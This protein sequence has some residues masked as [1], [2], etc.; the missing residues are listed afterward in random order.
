MND[1]VYE[2]FR[3]LIEPS[4]N[5]FYLLVLILMFQTYFIHIK[6]SNGFVKN[7]LNH[8][9]FRTNKYTDSGQ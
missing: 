5:L 1:Q 8:G 3:P 6:R 4:Q 2:H 9:T 7:C